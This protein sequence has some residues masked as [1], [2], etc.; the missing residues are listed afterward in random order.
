[1]PFYI[2]E[3]FK[4]ERIL[5]WVRIAIVVAIV[6]GLLGYYGFRTWKENPEMLKNLSAKIIEFFKV[7]EEAVEEE[8]LEEVAL[9][10]Q[11]LEIVLSKEK[12]YME[13][14]ETGEGITHLARKALKKYLSEKPQNFEVT[15]EHKIYIEDYLTK[16]KGGHW[17]KIGETLE[18]SGDLIQSA[19]DEAETLTPEQLQ[20]L[21]QFSQLVP[22]L[23]Y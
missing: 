21:T 10:E 13:I 12:T 8:A 14:A 1:M 4:R 9:E 18:F 16:Q 23:N 3:I 15:P 19:I 20:N 2:A 17:L 5:K 7:K 22:S 6:G 11:E